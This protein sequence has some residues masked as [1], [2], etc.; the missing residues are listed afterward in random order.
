MDTA[1]TATTATI[2]TIEREALTQ[3]IAVDVAR[4]LAVLNGV[5]RDW[6]VGDRTHD[7][8]L[9]LRAAN[10]VAVMRGGTSGGHCLSRSGDDI[11][12][13]CRRIAAHWIGYLTNNGAVIPAI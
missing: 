2:D 4:D 11:A 6:H 1:T 13:W 9:T 5:E 12:T 3:K 8:C 10:D 7:V